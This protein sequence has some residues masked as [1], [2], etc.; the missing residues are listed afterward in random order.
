MTG[1]LLARDALSAVDESA[2]YELLR[3]QFL[4]LSWD[5]FQADLDSKNWVILL[6]DKPGGRLCGLSTLAL[7]DLEVDGRELSVVC[8]GDTVVDPAAWRRQAMSYL[9]IGAVNHLRQVTG[10]RRLYWLLIVSG[11]RTYRF[12]PVYWREFF[13]HYDRPTP[14]E[15]QVLIDRL[16]TSRY[17]TNYLKDQGIVRFADPQVLK[18][19]FLGIPPHRMADPHVAFFAEKNPRHEAGDELV[20]IA[21]MEYE[22]LTRAGAKMWRRGEALFASSQ[23][24]A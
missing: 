6:D 13:P 3:T 24:L 20:C 22:N 14:P 7:Y 9:W 21:D 16:A 17:G 19:G 8:S 23:A 12:L 5:R 11:Y 18:D 4:G 2:M 15:K 10:R 1:R